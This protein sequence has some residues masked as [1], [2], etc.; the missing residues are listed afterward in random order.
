MSLSKPHLFSPLTLRSVTLRNRIGMSPMCQYSSVDGFAND[1]HLVHLGS[2]AAGGAGLIIVEATAVT[3]EGRISYA[4]LGLWDDRHIEKLAQITRFISEQ[5]AVPAIQ[6]GHAGRKASTNRP[7]DGGGPIK[8]TEANGWQT[9]APSPVPFAQ[10]YPAPKELT[11]D[12][13]ER[14]IS[15]FAEAVRRAKDAGFQIV[16][17][18]A[19]HGYLIHQF[20]SPVSNRRTDDYGGSFENR[21]RFL[22]E[23]IEATRREW[24]DDLPLFVRI[25]A[26]D[27]LEEGGWDLSQSVQLASLLKE[28]GVDLID[29]SSGG[30]VPTA[31]IPV[32]P[33][34]QVSFAET[35]RREAGIATSAVGLITT[36]EQAED[37]LSQ[38]KAD[39]ILLGRELL[40][41]PYWP[42]RAAM[43]LG[44]QLPY[45]PPQY[46][47]SVSRK[48]VGEPQ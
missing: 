39:M 6:L 4:D 31:Q 38:G 45:W 40:R 15:S 5:G 16:E 27:W 30:S 28:K 33:G 20:L 11:V 7:W 3:P 42:L 36:P 35:I 44:A 25:S 12:E 21:C 26:T 37:I 48:L 8:P 29:V 22:V 18:H 9:V 47:R 32:G 10:G 43:S 14:L 2:R 13:I 1:W 46:H 24:P 23:I 34:Y 17:I 19:A 41:D